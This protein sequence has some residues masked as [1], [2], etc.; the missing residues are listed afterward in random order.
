MR[1]V[2]L[3]TRGAWLAA[4]LLGVACAGS[5]TTTTVE[6]PPRVDLRAH[7]KIG[8]VEIGGDAEASLRSFATLSLLETLQSAQPGVPILELGEQARVLARVE[9][10]ALDFDAVRAIGERYHVDAV[11]VGE[12]QV[13]DVKPRLKVSHGL[14]S[15]SAKAQIDASLQ[16]RLLEVEAGATLWTAAVEESQD[17]AHLSLVS[18]GP[19]DFGAGSP[20]DARRQLVHRLIHAAAVDFHPRYVER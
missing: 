8:L 3:R 14:T 1:P 10:E 7:G 6:L 17:V 12:L 11:L 13:R 9:R 2:R 4:A 5:K 16:V 20:E 15:L 18:R 19:A